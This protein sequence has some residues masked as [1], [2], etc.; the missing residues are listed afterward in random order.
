MLAPSPDNFGIQLDETSHWN[1]LTPRQEWE[2]DS[3]KLVSELKP[4]K[5]YGL[6]HKLTK[7]DA[8]EIRG[9]YAAEDITQQQL[10]REYR[11]ALSTITDIIHYKTHKR[12][13]VL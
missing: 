12:Y 5:G 6:R 10:A 13:E 4:A 7:D 2:V 3:R 8:W 9:R 1:S 11:V